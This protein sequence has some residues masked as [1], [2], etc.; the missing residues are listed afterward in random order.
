MY[1][2]FAQDE[3]EASERARTFKDSDPFPKVPPALLS[4]EH[5]YDYVRTTALLHP[6]YTDSN[7]LKPAFV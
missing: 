6:F 7:R 1:Y 5:I 3:N 2:E 4:A